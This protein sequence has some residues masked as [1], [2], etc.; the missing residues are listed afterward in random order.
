[1]PWSSSGPQTVRARQRRAGIVLSGLVQCDARRRH[2][3]QRARRVVA[4]ARIVDE[5][6]CRRRSS[7]SLA[8]GSLLGREECELRLREVRP[9][10]RRRRRVPVSTAAVRSSVARSV[11]PSSACATPRRSATADPTTLRGQLIQRQIGVGERL[12]DTVRHHVRPQGGDPGLDRRAAIRERDRR[13]CPVSE[14]EPALGICGPARQRADPGTD[15]GECGVSPQLVI[16]EPSEPLL[17]GLHPAVVVDRQ[18]KGVDQAGDGVRLTRSVP[19][20]DR[21]LVEVVGDAPR[22]RPTVEFG[23]HVRLAALELGAQQLAE[24]VVVAIPLA[25]SVER[26]HEAVPALERLEYAAPT[27]SSGARHR[28]GR[29]TCDPAPRCT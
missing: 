17:Q 13:G 9:P 10:R 25:S 23:H 5:R 16:A 1:M 21:R 14:S 6:L 11:A 29:R 24:Q 15:N 7:P 18:G 2:V 26:H 3:R 8:P 12:L 20:D 27:A 4:E 19:V 22:H 28:K